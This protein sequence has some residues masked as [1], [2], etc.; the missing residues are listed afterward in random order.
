MIPHGSKLSHSAPY[1]HNIF[2]TSPQGGPAG[3]RPPF[4]FKNVPAKATPFEV[5]RQ[6]QTLGI[7][8]EKRRSLSLLPST[9]SVARRLGL[10]KVS[11]RYITASASLGPLPRSRHR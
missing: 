1:Q 11:P 4:S 5:R 9:A 10:V 6:T 7:R 2:T 3:L 8:R